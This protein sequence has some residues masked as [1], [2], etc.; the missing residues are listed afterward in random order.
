MVGEKPS[1][2]N[3]KIE[4]KTDN[5]K[6]TKA[7]DLFSEL[8]IE[9]LNFRIQKNELNHRRYLAMSTWLD[10]AGYTNAAK[11]WKE[12]SNDENKH[13]FLARQILISL[14]I[15]SDV[16]AV[17]AI[18]ND[19]KDLPDIIRKTYFNKI[20]VA[21]KCKTYAK[22]SLNKG[23][24]L[25]NQYSLEYLNEIIGELGEFQTLIDKLE[26]FGEDKIAI[27]FLEAD[28]A[29]QLEG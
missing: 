7:S 9:I 13:S 18:E 6:I 4:T 12:N 21:D 8:A 28:I 16:K 15:Y 19:F 14:G 1:E 11:L 5:V 3:K 26:A 29:E 27:R 25:A 20:E 10:N 17:D 23:D 24:T 2:E 22:D